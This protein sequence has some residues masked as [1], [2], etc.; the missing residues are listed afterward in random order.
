V[1]MPSAVR[2]EDNTM[3]PTVGPEYRYSAVLFIEKEGFDEL[4]SAAQ[5]SERYDIGLMSTKGLSVGAARRLVDDLAG[6][7][8]RVFVMHDFDLS[9]FKIFGTLG[10]D[11][12]VHTFQNEVDVVDIGLRLADVERLSLQHEPVKIEGNWSAHAATLKRHGATEAEIRFLMKDRVELNM[13]TAPVFVEFLEGKFAEHGI[14]KV[15]PAAKV[16]EAHARRII[17]QD[18][19][20]ELIEKSLPKIQKEAKAV[21]LPKDFLGQV[22]ALLAI[23]PELSWDMAL[24]QIIRTEN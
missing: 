12:K 19:A 14:K 10:T 4:W 15:I 21:Q 5:I 24:A 6:R 20:Q 8:V 2:L 11:S 9:G 1:E 7:G 22:K 13:M 16:L 3:Y 23:S 18:L 17:E